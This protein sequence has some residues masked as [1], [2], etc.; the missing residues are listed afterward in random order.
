MSHRYM[1]TTIAKQALTAFEWSAAIRK[2]FG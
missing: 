2:G 1:G